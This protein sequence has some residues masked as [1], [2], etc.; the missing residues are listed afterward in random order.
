MDK[1]VDFSL[2]TGMGLTVKHLISAVLNF[3]GTMNMI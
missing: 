2:K 3:R 1:L